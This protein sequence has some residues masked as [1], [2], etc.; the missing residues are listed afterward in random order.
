M[1]Q[2]KEYITFRVFRRHWQCRRPHVS[3]FRWLQGVVA[4]VKNRRHSVK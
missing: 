2:Y 3:K 4:K 1:G